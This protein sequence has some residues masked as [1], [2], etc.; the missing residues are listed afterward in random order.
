MTGWSKNLWF[1][2]TN[3]IWVNPSP[4]IPDLETAIIYPGMCLIEGTNISEGRGTSHPFKWIGAPWIEGQKLSQALNKFDLP[5]VVFVPKSF[6][7][8]NIP[9][10]AENTKFENQT[11][12]G[13]EIWLTDRNT[14]KSIDTGLLTLFTIYAMYPEQTEFREKHLNMLWGNDKLFKELVKGSTGLYFLKHYK[15]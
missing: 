2:E 3:L 4:N 15:N 10:K 11:C 7:P 13:V 8:V 6:T 1:D 9:G 12:S 14:F 5:G